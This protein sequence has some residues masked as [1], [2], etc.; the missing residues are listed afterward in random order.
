MTVVFL[1]LMLVP[2]LLIEVGFLTV[3]SLLLMIVTVSLIVEGIVTIIN[4]LT[5]GSNN[6]IDS[7]HGSDYNCSLTCGS[8]NDSSLTYYGNYSFT[9]GSAGNSSLHDDVR[10]VSNGNCVTLYIAKAL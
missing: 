2:V 1:L 5:A 3:I 9:A 4:N 6:L 10:C 7:G 8:A